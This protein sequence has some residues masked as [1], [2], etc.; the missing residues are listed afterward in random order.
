MA[1]LGHDGRPPCR[2]I[3]PRRA[4]APGDD[5]RSAGVAAIG[6]PLCPTPWERERSAAGLGRSEG[7]S[8][9]KGGA[10]RGREAASPRGWGRRG[11]N[12]RTSQPAGECADR[13]LGDR[14]RRRRAATAAADEVDGL[15]QCGAGR[16]AVLLAPRA[17]SPPNA[18]SSVPAVGPVT[19]VGVR[20]R[21]DAPQGR[22]G[23]HRA[24][25]PWA[26]SNG[27]RNFGSQ[28]FG[29][30]K[31]DP[32]RNFGAPE[33]RGRPELWRAGGP[34]P[35]ETSTLQRP[36]TGQNFGASE[37]EAGRNLD[38][39]EPEAGRGSSAH[40]GF[41]GTLEPEAGRGF[42]GALES[43]AS[44]GFLGAP[45]F[46][47]APDLEAGRGSSARWSPRMASRSSSAGWGFLDAPEPDAGPAFVGALVPRAG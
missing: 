23:G 8:V 35:A 10:G 46:V 15:G 32:G 9:G 5:G 26:E 31:A 38:A 11:R 36:E 44:W 19:D 34:R 43:E 17:I 40:R 39:L 6:P 2:P 4:T 3:Q 18:A 41:L 47:G 45:G 29:A 28:N 16:T 42:L 30:P 22:E 13:G 21:E 14:L 7:V 27:R 1:T 24:R 20:G 33:A 37:P 12:T 25:A